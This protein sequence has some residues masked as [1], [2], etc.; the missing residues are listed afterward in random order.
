MDELLTALNFINPNDLPY[1]KWLSVGMALYYEGYPCDVWDLWSQSDRRYKKG[2]CSAKWK[3]FGGK[4]SHP[5]AGTVYALAKENG[6]QKPERQEHVR[7]PEEELA[8]FL[9][10]LFRPE[11]IVGYVTEFPDGRPSRGVYHRTCGELLRELAKHPGDLG[12][13]IGDWDKQQGALIRVNPL[14]GTGVKNENVTDY[15]YVLVEADSLSLREQEQKLR[16]LEL[17]IAT[18]VSSGGRSIHAMVHIDAGNAAEYAER[19]EFLF[20]W[21]Q[22][23]GFPADPATKNPARMTRLPGVTR[24]GKPQK[25]LDVNLGPKSWEE[26]CRGT[27]GMEDRFSLDKYFFDP[28]DLPE[29]LISGILRCGHKMLIAGPSKAGKSFLLMELCIA[30]A[31]GRPWLGFPCRK[32]KVLYINLEI[33]KRS[34]LHRFIKIYEALDIPPANLRN[35]VVWNMRG[36]AKP[37]EDMVPELL[38]YIV[39][40]GFDAVVFDPLYKLLGKFDENSASDMANLCNAFDKVCTRAGVAAIYAHHHSKGAQGGK[41]AQDRSSGSGVFARDPDAILDIIE[42]NLT[43]D[44]KNFVADPG[45]TAWRLECSL[46]EFRNFQPLNFWFRYPIHE[47]DTTGELSRCRPDGDPE[48]AVVTKEGRIQKKEN[49]KQDLINAY[50]ALNQDGKVKITALAQYFSV[51]ERRM[52]ERVNE[53][54]DIFEHGKGYITLKEK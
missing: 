30:L 27:F 15:R 46:R 14:D 3:G 32:S 53:A 45:N 21:L 18:L 20:D 31:E 35:I 5:A 2:E 28:P 12:A 47:T 4:V 26:F 25:L 37:L 6:W 49:S 36:H 29:E 42:L 19:V 39:G 9:R 43:D 41:K 22:Q 16:A 44:L 8:L 34:C 40:Q 54:L 23:Q 51:S 11:D 24:N 7:K 38:D 1:Q 13:V 50:Y 33:D 52:R 17:P 48:T 10:T